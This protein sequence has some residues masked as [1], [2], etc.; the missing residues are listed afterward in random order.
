MANLSSTLLSMPWFLLARS[1]NERE[2][3]TDIVNT[4]SFHLFQ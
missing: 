2:M 3:K 4:P 1:E